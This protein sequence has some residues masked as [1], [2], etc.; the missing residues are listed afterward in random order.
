M[1][2]EF[3][4]KNLLKTGLVLLKKKII[5]EYGLLIIKKDKG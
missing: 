4:S 2:Q 1:F 3:P 5:A